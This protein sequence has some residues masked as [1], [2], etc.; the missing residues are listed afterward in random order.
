MVGCVLPF[1]FMP[2]KALFG[3]GLSAGSAAARITINGIFSEAAFAARPEDSMST[4]D[5]LV[6]WRRDLFS[7]I[8]AMAVSEVNS[9]LV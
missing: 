2:I 4:I 6:R 3:S 7:L 5:A 1:G 9:V 8:V